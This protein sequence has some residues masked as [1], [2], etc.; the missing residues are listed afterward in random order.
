[1]ADNIKYRFIQNVGEYFP[2][3]YFGDDFLEKVQ[4]CAGLSSEEVKTLCSPFV[5]LQH[6]YDEYK[7]FIINHN[8]RIEDAVKKTDI[9]EK[10][11]KAIRA[12]IKKMMS[13]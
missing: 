6:D 10:M 7:N 1:M 4:K 12:R 8:P 3:G 13:Q 11:V 9:P 5:R 2:S